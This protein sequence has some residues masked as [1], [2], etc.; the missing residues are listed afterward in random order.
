MEYLAPKLDTTVIQLSQVQTLST[1]PLN[2]TLQSFNFHKYKHGVPDPPTW[3]YSH[4]TFTSTNMEYLAP[5]LDTIVIKLSQV[6][7]WSTWP[8]NL[9]LQSFNFHKYKHGVPDPPTWH[10]S[11]ST[12]TSTNMEYLAPK[13]DTIVIQLSQVQTWS[14]WPLNLTLQSF[15]FHKYKHGVPDPPTWHYSHSTFTSTNM[16]YLAPKLDTTVIQLSQVQTWSTWPL[17]LTLQSFNFH[18]YK[19]GVPGP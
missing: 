14:T 5:K 4:S 9:T 7:T 17:N 2:L 6:Q 16:E 1:W 8:L 15:N 19:H 18:K 12:F 10:Y 3:H 13:L 11:H